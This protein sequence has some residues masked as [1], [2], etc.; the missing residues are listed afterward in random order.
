MILVCFIIFN[1]THIP[2]M[3]ESAVCMK[4]THGDACA[5]KKDVI[6]RWNTSIP[7]G[8]YPHTSPIYSAPFPGSTVNGNSYLQQDLTWK[9]PMHTPLKNSEPYYLNIL[10]NPCKLVYQVKP[11]WCLPS[12]FNGT[13]S[14]RLALLYHQNFG[15]VYY[16]TKLLDSI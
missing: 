15:R 10:S 3:S 1:M 16:S 9:N 7:L 6:S 14:P 11:R 8:L 12:I 4:S 5:S 2:V 13:K